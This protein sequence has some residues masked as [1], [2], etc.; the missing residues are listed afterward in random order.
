M[1]D[2]LFPLSVC[3]SL[4][5]L[6]KRDFQMVA[7]NESGRELVPLTPLEEIGYIVQDGLNLL[8]AVKAFPDKRHAPKKW[9]AEGRELREVQDAQLALELELYLHGVERS[10]VIQEL[11][12]AWY[13]IKM[14]ADVLRNRSEYKLSDIEPV[15]L[16]ADLIT[17]ADHLVHCNLSAS[18]V[19][20]PSNRI[21]A[22]ARSSSP[23]APAAR[24]V[25]D[26]LEKVMAGY[27]QV[28]TS[29]VVWRAEQLLAG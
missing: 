6:A 14:L 16:A 3:G 19:C 5:V 13:P 11:R 23:S 9:K 12:P 20:L 27:V 21:K 8:T 22:D 1:P 15:Q 2:I 29:A 4:V 25:L 10:F 18:E 28:H 7:I 17:H 26:Y 24:L